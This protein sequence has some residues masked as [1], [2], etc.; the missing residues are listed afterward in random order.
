[1]PELSKPPLGQSFFR[2]PDRREIEVVI[3]ETEDGRILARTRDE[4]ELIEK[5]RQAPRPPAAGESP[6]G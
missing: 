2:L 5:S 3:V 6:R 1:M 4:L